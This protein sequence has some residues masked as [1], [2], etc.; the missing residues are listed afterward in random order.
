MALTTWYS[1]LKSMTLK[2]RVTLR[3]RRLYSVRVCDC[4]RCCCG[5]LGISSIG[6]CVFGWLVWSCCLRLGVGH[7]ANGGFV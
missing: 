4:I 1:S 3:S 2:E 6:V 5:S 7:S